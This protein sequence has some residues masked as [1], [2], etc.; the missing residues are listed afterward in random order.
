MDMMPP[1]T[2]RFVVGVDEYNLIIL[3]HAILVDPI[4]V[5]YPQ[6]ATTTANTFFSNTPQTTL[7][8]EMVDTLADR[9]AIC[10]A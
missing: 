4:R 1:D 10:R 7:E 8:L 5:Q 3:V 2:Y 6:V 9:F